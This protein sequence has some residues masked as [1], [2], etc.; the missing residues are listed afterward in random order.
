M[1]G[2][3]SLERKL[4]KHATTILI[5][6]IFLSFSVLMFLSLC[7]MP[8]EDQTYGVLHEDVV[9][10]HIFSPSRQLTA[11]L[12][13]L[14]LSA[15]KNNKERDLI[16]DTWGHGLE[17]KV[18]LKFFIG[19][20]NLDSNQSKTLH[21]EN[22]LHNDLVLLKKLNESF[23]ALTLKVLESFKWIDNNINFKH[24]L[25]TD[26]DSY[27]RVQKIIN[28]LRNKP[29]DR[30]YWGFFDGRA[31][32]KKRGKWSEKDWV[33]CDRYLPY[34]LGGGYVISNDLVHYVVQNSKFLKIYNNEDVSLGTW[35]GPLDINR[36][37][38]PRFNTEYKSR[39]CNN[40]YLITHKQTSMQMREL[41]NNI[42]KTG[43]LC[44]KE[45]Q[46]RKSYI[47]NWDSLPTSCCIRNNSAIP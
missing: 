20:G 45:F 6:G 34:A 31:H 18:I 37:H 19:I 13:I 39:G 1:R 2:M 33:L 35:L 30:F 23:K 42:L 44:T 17:K 12:V 47:Y 8:C 38:D 9:K 15:P 10:T 21:S 43:Q 40:Q 46:I 28:E 24:L 27:V 22:L 25:K 4:N 36:I 7:N 26:E 32:V 3:S 14:I 41:H 11:D 29:E 5:G 16:R